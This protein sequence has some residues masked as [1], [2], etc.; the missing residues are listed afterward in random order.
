MCS[1]Y[2]SGAGTLRSAIGA[3]L[4]EV[5]LERWKDREA[6]TLSRGLR[7]RLTIARALLHNPPVLLLDE[8]F[9]GLDRHSARIFASRLAKLREEGRTILLVT[10][11]LEEGWTLADTA[12][13]LVRGKIAHAV[14]VT[15]DGM[16]DFATVFDRLLEGNGA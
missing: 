9:T 16:Q 13:I 12:A 7:Q 8:P 15:P 11:H 14:D 3:L 5:E 6:G 4:R 2:L 10:H 1:L